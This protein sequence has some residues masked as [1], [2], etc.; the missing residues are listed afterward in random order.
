V[1]QFLGLRLF[2]TG[3]VYPRSVGEQSPA[4]IEDIIEED[5]DLGRRGE[6]RGLNHAVKPQQLKQDIPYPLTLP[7]CV[8]LAPHQI[9]LQHD[10]NDTQYAPLRLTQGHRFEI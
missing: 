6:S 3:G 8:F 9:D 10:D 7:K 2:D 4:C 1:A 5:N